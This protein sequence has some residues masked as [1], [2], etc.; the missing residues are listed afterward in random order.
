MSG[1][2]GSFQLGGTFGRSATTESSGTHFLRQILWLV[3]C[4][5]MSNE[6]ADALNWQQ[7]LR[8][9]F[10]AA[11]GLEY[12]HS[13]CNPAI[14]HRDV[15]SSN[16]LLN[17]NFEAKI[18]DFGLSRS[19]ISSSVTHITTAVAGTAGYLDPEYWY[20]SKVTE[21]SDV[22]GF[23]VVLF[24]LI[25]GQHAISTHGG[26]SVPIVQIV[27]PRLSRGDINSIIDPRIQG[28]YEISSIW[29][30]ADTA[31]SCTQEKS[32]IRPTMRDVVAELKE[33]ME[34]E[35]A[36]ERSDIEYKEQN[37]NMTYN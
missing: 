1:D 33:A 12:L 17:A 27:V 20:T 28:Q 5:G 4:K 36:R 9:A 29:K 30:V 25:T 24:E 32:F 6:R 31:M 21:K 7:R 2:R 26:E 19:V 35:M 3:L 23:G 8:I 22:Y 34:I 13:G 10:G 11:T 16:I 14:I 15:K 18:A 37:D